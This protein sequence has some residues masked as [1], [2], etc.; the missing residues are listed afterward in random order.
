[1]CIYIC[2]EFDLHQLT[3]QE[4]GVLGSY[5]CHSPQCIQNDVRHVQVCQAEIPRAPTK[6]LR[7]PYPD[8]TAVPIS[9]AGSARR[10]PRWTSTR[11]EK[12]PQRARNIIDPPQQRNHPPSQEQE[13]LQARGDARRKGRKEAPPHLSIQDRLWPLLPIYATSARHD[14]CGVGPSVYRGGFQYVS[15][16]SPA[17][18]SHP[19]VD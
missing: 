9:S 3:Y 15:F 4:P 16:L 11:R 8:R 5:Q 12:P 13:R 6:V 18:S 1:M 7:T 17:P 10:P 14:D 19:G 2:H